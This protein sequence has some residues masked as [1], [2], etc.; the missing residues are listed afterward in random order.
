MF[1]YKKVK[2]R[3]MVATLAHHP[4]TDIAPKGKKIVVHIYDIFTNKH[5][6]IVHPYVLYNIYTCTIFINLVFTSI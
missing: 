1:G 2:L 5:C 4:F 3:I 6:T